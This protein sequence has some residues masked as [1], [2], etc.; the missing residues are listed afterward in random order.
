MHKSST[1][2]FHHCAILPYLGKRTRK[3][4]HV[5]LLHCR[6]GQKYGL[7]RSDKMAA[8]NEPNIALF[9]SWNGGIINPLFD[10][11]TYNTSGHFAHFLY[12]YTTQLAK[13]PR[14]LYVKP[15]NKVYQL[16]SV[17]M[18]AKTHYR[19][20]KKG[21]GTLKRPNRLLKKYK[22]TGCFAAYYSSQK[23]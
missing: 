5:I 19:Q 12:F 8:Q 10:G 4:C 23:Q 22:K 13:Y 11:L 17:R 1:L 2:L 14:V 21:V 9:T 15:S 20:Y 16:Y 7:K 18:L 6:T 3:I